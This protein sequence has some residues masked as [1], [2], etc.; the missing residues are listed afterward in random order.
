MFLASFSTGYSMTL[1]QLVQLYA[2]FAGLMALSAWMGALSQRVKHLE[3]EGINQTRDKVIALEVKVDNLITAS[4]RGTREIAGVHRQLANL[5]AGKLG[6]L[7][8]STPSQ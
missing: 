7:Y 4:E 1:T 6:A 3:G 8:E 2:P 5:A